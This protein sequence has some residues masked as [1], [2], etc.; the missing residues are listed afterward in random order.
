MRRIRHEEAFSTGHGKGGLEED[1]VTMEKEDTLFKKTN[2]AVL[3]MDDCWWQSEQG[4]RLVLVFA[5]GNEKSNRVFIHCS[6]QLPHMNRF[7]IEMRIKL[8][9]N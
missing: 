1:R 2:M 6:S 9:L 8:A 5:I 3:K 4:M 7:L